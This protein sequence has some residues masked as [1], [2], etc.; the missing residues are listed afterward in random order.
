MCPVVLL[1]L[2]LSL[3]L[4]LLELT[5]A[6]S[7][8]F[9]P[10]E[11]KQLKEEQSIFVTLQLKDKNQ[12]KT[13]SGYYEL[14]I[15]DKN[16][17]DVIGNKTFNFD[18]NLA[19][20]ESLNHTFELKG[21]FLGHTWLQVIKK[22][23]SIVSN[24]DLNYENEK[25]SRLAISVILPMSQITKIFTISV[26]VL[27]SINYINMGCALDLSVVLSVLKRPIAPAI[28]FVC[29]YAF[30]PLIAYFAAKLLFNESYLQ[31]GL[32]TFGCSPGGG[33]SNMWTVLLGGN[34]NLS[35]TMTFIS[36]LS[37]IFMMPLWLFT[38]GR[39]IFEGTTTTVKTTTSASL[40]NIVGTLVSMT[41]FL[42]LG[43]LF[44]KF[45]P[46]VAN[47]CRRILAPV[48]IAMIIF[49]ILFGTY[50]N[51]YMFRLMSWRIILAASIN[52]WSG[53]MVG[54][55]ASTSFRQP[56]VDRIAIAI[57]TGVQN[58]GV[59]IVLLRFAL[60][61]PDAD[62]ASVVP[63]AASV[64]TPIPLTIVYII[65]KL[66][67]CF[68]RSAKMKLKSEIFEDGLLNESNKTSSS[69]LPINDDVKDRLNWTNGHIS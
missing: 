28:G 32:F 39:N 17:V 3:L 6:L 46:K 11:V 2:I 68:N 36:T 66:R 48:S 37:A 42:G 50:A 34:L 23:N 20:Y 55:I 60:S 29:Q 21:K 8:T 18:N 35:I 14:Y 22:Y 62:L 12:L 51:L 30:M 40:P 7:V 19:N 13:N 43:L 24:S 61:Q 41:I 31:L 15:E 45:L 59:S 53:F 10:S 9:S 4:L 27:V 44:Q 63:V 26:A 16:I 49:I 69:T 5:A 1:A 47:I 33:A 65:I 52:V 64:M 54:L 57:E 67:N 58:T 56:L 25:S 38:L